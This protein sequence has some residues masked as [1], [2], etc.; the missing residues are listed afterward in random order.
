MF[1]AVWVAEQWVAQNAVLR[2]AQ[3]IFAFAAIDQ[4]LTTTRQ[5]YRSNDGFAKE[6]P[7][8]VKAFLSATRKRC[9]FC[10]SNR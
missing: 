10:V 8:A 9:E 5:S 3:L 2:T 1:D 7:D 4:N 6:N